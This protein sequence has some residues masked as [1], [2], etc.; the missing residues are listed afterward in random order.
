MALAP[1][2]LAIG[3]DEHYWDEELAQLMPWDATLSMPHVILLAPHPDDEVLAC[4]GLLQR[5]SKIALQLELWMVTD[6][7]AC[8]GEAVD[9]IDNLELAK[10]RREEACEAHRRLG[11]DTGVQV[12]WV[13]LPDG[14]V[15]AH[16]EQLRAA[17][18]QRL[19]PHT[20]L[21]APLATDG[22]PDHDVIGEVAQNLANA[23]GLLLLSYP[24][25][26][27]HWGAT[28]LL[29]GA[30]G[31]ARRIELSAAELCRK[32]DAIAA[33]SSQIQSEQSIEPILPR[34]VLRHFRRSFEVLF[35]EDC[36]MENCRVAAHS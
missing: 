29:N 4:G 3:R 16:R 34:R 15:Q 32:R 22:H 8:F 7:E 1:G 10:R 12:H 33:F 26:L 28:H 30:T 2:R 21:V 20:V 31:Q 27:R 9:N 6:G 14:K 25:W 11:I 35:M 5:W 13:G 36:R 24:V 19:T 18:Q 23:H 17:L